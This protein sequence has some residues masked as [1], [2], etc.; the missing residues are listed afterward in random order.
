MKKKE[1]EALIIEL[2]L[3]THTTRRALNLIEMVDRIEILKKELGS[4]SAVAKKLDLSDEIIREFWSAK[5]LPSE[6]KKIIRNRNIDSLDIAYRISLLK[7]KDKQVCLA[8]KIIE[9]G[10]TSKAVRG[11][12]SILRRDPN[13][14]IEEAINKY[15]EIKNII[16][17]KIIFPY[18]SLMRNNQKINN[19]NIKMKIKRELG[20]NSIYEFSITNRFVTLILSE[21]GFRT[22]KK[23]AKEKE[24]TKKELIFQ[25][26][27]S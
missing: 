2:I 17:Y 3:N 15:N 24:I 14:T 11:V 7:D 19:Q 23:K 10:L 27:S 18:K 5:T 21:D 9:G 8:L 25:T 22:L 12:V 4:L 1:I 20:P 13:K 6:V 26:I 16:R